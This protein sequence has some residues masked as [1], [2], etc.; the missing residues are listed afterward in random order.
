MK[1]ITR[2]LLVAML[3]GSAGYSL[4]ADSDRWETLKAINLIENPTNSARPGA[5][6]ELGPYQFRRTTWKLHTN[7][8]FQLALDRQHA[9]EVAVAHYEWIKAGLERAGIAAT[10]YNI[11]LAWN[12]GLSAAIDGRAARASRG[13][14]TRVANITESLKRSDSTAYAMSA[15]AST[16]SANIAVYITPMIQID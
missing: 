9:D 5:H 11:A 3:V 1:L 15:P 14:A 6:G 7:R 2:I 13:Y 10:P 8:S 4:A 16:G 12:S